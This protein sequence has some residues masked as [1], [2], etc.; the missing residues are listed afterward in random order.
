MIEAAPGDVADAEHAH[1]LGPGYVEAAGK[2][3]LSHVRNELAGA[4]VFDEPAIALAPGPR[5]KWLAC[6]IAME[7]YGHH[8]RFQRL[9]SELG[10]GPAGAQRTLS[11][12]DFELSS[13]VE[14][15]VLKAVVDLAEVVL[16]EELLETSY[17]PL[18][19]LA[20]KLLPEERF[21]VSFGQAPSRELAAD[22]DRRAAV[23]QAV[24]A[25]VPF[26]TPFFGRSR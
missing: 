22:P 24:D 10:L 6:R 2:V 20:A 16:M 11:V 26:T 7:E 9:A 17:L 13:W 1:R 14:F 4:S 8:L 21:H 25:L 18:R 15:V 12:F 3:I 23:Q 5:E 19:A